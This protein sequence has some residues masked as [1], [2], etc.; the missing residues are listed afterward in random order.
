M[1]AAVTHSRSNNNDPANKRQRKA[2]INNNDANITLGFNSWWS[3]ILIKDKAHNSLVHWHYHVVF[4][5]Q[6]DDAIIR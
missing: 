5:K 1:E 2:K 4:I 6:D 3:L